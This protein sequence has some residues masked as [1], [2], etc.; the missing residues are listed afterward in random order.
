[1]RRVFKHRHLNSPQTVG[2]LTLVVVTAGSSTGLTGVQV[3]VSGGSSGFSRHS[4][5][6]RVSWALTEP[7]PTPQGRGTTC[8]AFV[9]V[10]KSHMEATGSQREGIAGRKEDSHCVSKSFFSQLQ[11]LFCFLLKFPFFFLFLT[12]LDLFSTLSLLHPSFYLQRLS[13]QDWPH[14]FIKQSKSHC[15]LCIN[16]SITELNHKSWESP[17]L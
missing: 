12:V 17:H 3:L 14:R 5:P 10:H 7:M 4:R 9:L 11:M 1:M 15:P 6:E 16:I 8:A 2:R 13:I